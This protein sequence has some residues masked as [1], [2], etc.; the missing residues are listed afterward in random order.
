MTKSAQFE[1]SDIPVPTI[2][3]CSL[4]MALAWFVYGNSHAPEAA[5]VPGALAGL[6]IALC[7]GREDWLHRWRDFMLFGAVGWAFG[8]MMP[9][10]HLMG[11]TNTGALFWQDMFYGTSALALTGFIWAG[12]GG[13]ISAIPA[14][15]SSQDLRNCRHVL[16]VVIACW[17]LTK[18]LWFYNIPSEEYLDGQ[19]YYYFFNQNPPG[20]FSISYYIAWCHFH[21]I[22]WLPV[23]FILAYLL[24]VILTNRQTIATS[25]LKN[26][27]VGWI[28]GIVIIVCLFQ[29]RLSPPQSDVW[30]GLL[31]ILLFLMVALIRS[32]RTECRALFFVM[33]ITAFWGAVALPLANTFRLYVFCQNALYPS[34]QVMLLS[35]GFIFGIGLTLALSY[36]ASYLSPALPNGSESNWKSPTLFLAG[37]LLLAVSAFYHFV[38]LRW[39]DA[40]LIPLYPQDIHLMFWVFMAAFSIFVL[41]VMVQWVNKDLMKPALPLVDTALARWLF[42]VMLWM[43]WA[44]SVMQNAAVNQPLWINALLWISVYAIT[45]R[46]LIPPET[47][48]APIQ[49][50]PWSNEISRRSVQH[51]L[52]WLIITGLFITVLTLIHKGLIQY[53]T[54]DHFFRYGPNAWHPG[55]ESFLYPNPKDFKG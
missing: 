38:L 22:P 5:A 34:H 33:L 24:F 41:V 27:L 46:V 25:L 29:F 55:I 11:Y 19:V 13:L 32:K 36:C 39:V 23:L 20:Y 47:V 14:L 48:M 4:T 16:F 26:A 50:N 53:P 51:I 37:L 45:L 42:V 18:V 52:S 1:Y 30:A 7:Y 35:Q 28:A 17:L 49:N 54:Q 44:M 43:V 15:C 10:E 40:K 21:S 6:S 2:F 3:I 31:G 9:V 12:I 8:G